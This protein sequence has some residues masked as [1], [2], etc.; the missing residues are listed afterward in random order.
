MQ[1]LTNTGR[2][3]LFQDAQDDKESRF[4]QFLLS[5]G[6]QFLGDYENGPFQFSARNQYIRYNNQYYRLNS[7][8]DVGFTTSGST[9]ATFANDVNHFVLMDG[10]TLRQNLRSNEAGQGASLSGLEQGGTVQDAMNYVLAGD[11]VRIS[12]FITKGLSDEAAILAALVVATGENNYIARPI[13]NDTG[14][15]LELAS[16]IAIQSHAGVSVSGNTYTGN[17][18]GVLGA[19]KL[20]NGGGFDFANTYD[21]VIDVTITDGGGNSINTAD[22]TQS[23]FAIK[24]TG[25]NNI[26]PTLRINGY[27]YKG[28]L[29]GSTDTNRYNV[30]CLRD[31]TINAYSCGGPVCFMHETGFGNFINIWQELCD[32]GPYIFDVNDF[33]IHNYENYQSIAN[34]GGEFVIQNCLSTHITNFLSGNGGNPQ[35]KIYDSWVDIKTLL[36]IPGPYKN[37]QATADYYGVEVAASKVQIGKMT[38]SCEGNIMKAGHDAFIFIGDYTGEYINQFLRITN[39]MSYPGGNTGTTATV[40][41]N[42]IYVSY[43]NNDYCYSSKSCIS[44]DS[45]MMINLSVNSGSVWWSNSR[46]IDANYGYFIS[47]GDSANSRFYIDNVQLNGNY[48]GGFGCTFP[49]VLCIRKLY[50][51]GRESLINGVSTIGDSTVLPTSF[52]IPKDTSAF[53]SSYAKYRGYAYVTLSAGASLTVQKNGNTIAKYSGITGQ[54]PLPVI[55]LAPKETARYYGSGTYTLDGGY[56]E[57]LLW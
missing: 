52:L 4:Q 9:G 37:N 29:T 33:T 26:G 6:Y 31:S 18:C 41:I 44:V 17:R 14:R 8:T 2:N 54:L 13:W 43:G 34:A 12:T 5:S 10:D 22:Q 45:G 49:N 27:S 16:R 1:R 28:W 56:G 15:A 40:S 32:H 23:N 47:G 21:A 46:T 36:V 3:N 35:L 20:T 7:S 11:V 30:Q 51:P 19:F 39:E 55:E 42:S 57:Y 53:V 50:T 48:Q 25:A 24:F 38:S